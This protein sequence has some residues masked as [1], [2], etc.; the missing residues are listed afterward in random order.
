MACM[1]IP[2]GDAPFPSIQSTFRHRPDLWSKLDS[3]WI[4][5]NMTTLQAKQHLEIVAGEPRM[6]EGDLTYG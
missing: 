1:Q 4:D 6:K 5:I 2:A 3:A